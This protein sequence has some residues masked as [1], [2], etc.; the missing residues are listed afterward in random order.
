LNLRAEHGGK[1]GELRTKGITADEE[2][3]KAPIEFTYGVTKLE[4]ST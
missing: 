4:L 1:D 3:N 2:K